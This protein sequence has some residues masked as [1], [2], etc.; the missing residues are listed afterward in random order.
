ML[1]GGFYYTTYCKFLKVCIYSAVYFFGIILEIRKEIGICELF[2][3]G[4][5]LD[6]VDCGGRYGHVALRIKR[7]TQFVQLIGILLGDLFHVLRK[8]F[9]IGVGGVFAGIKGVIVSVRESLQSFVKL[10]FAENR[11]RIF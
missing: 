3:V 7:Y 10:A 1:S 2:A 8:L 6:M 11:I 4:G 9:D 5:K